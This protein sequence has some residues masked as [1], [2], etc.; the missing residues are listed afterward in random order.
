MYPLS[1]QFPQSIFLTTKKPIK[2]AEGPEGPTRTPLY[3]SKRLCFLYSSKRL[4]SY[5]KTQIFC[6]KIQTCC[7]IDWCYFV[8]NSLVAL[9]LYVLESFL[10]DSWISVF[11]SEKKFIG[12]Y[13]YIFF[14]C[15]CVCKV[16]NR[17]FLPPLSTRLLCL[18]VSIPLVCWLYMCACVC[19][20]L[21]V[22]VK[23]CR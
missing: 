10:L 16:S 8:R 19:V 11:V 7:A 9:K 15:V 4:W 6:A 17:A 5:A 1:N 13:I 12:I 2:P 14:F 22:H 18:V 3:S 23:M 21:Y 20:P